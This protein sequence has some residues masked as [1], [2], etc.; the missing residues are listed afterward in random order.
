MTAVEAS[1]SKTMVREGTSAVIE[2][3]FPMWLCW[4]VLACRSSKHVS[5][6]TLPF[7]TGR[8]VDG[9]RWDQ[10]LGWFD[11]SRTFD[12]TLAWINVGEMNKG[13]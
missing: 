8:T 3:H 2:Q 6:W 10:E 9:K 7:G 1:A 5:S 4:D 13:F 11:H 12:D